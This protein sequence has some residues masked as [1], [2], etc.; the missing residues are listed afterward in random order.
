MSAVTT[1]RVVQ[2][3]IEPRA[4][5]AEA[6]S[7][8]HVARRDLEAGRALTSLRRLRLVE[9]RGSELDEAS[10]AERLHASTQFYNPAKER[11]V[12]RAAD[13]TPA[14]IGPGEVPLCVAERGAT[15][16]TSAERWWRHA[17]GETVEV[18]EAVVWVLGFE[19]GARAEALARELAAVRD[20]RN[21]L[22][23]NPHFQ[24]WALASGAPPRPWIDAPVAAGRAQRRRDT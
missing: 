14:P 10:L 19:P 11:C 2:A 1:G 17:T 13:A 3:W 5:D 16:R 20:R 24:D 8:L 9:V 7:A 18:H 15:R 4:E 23:C 22:F 12:V 6:V 21:G